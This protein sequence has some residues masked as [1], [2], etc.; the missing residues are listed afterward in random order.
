MASGRVNPLMFLVL[1]AVLS[2][3]K[4]V[5]RLSTQSSISCLAK[6][7]IN[8]RLDGFV[9]MSWTV[10]IQMSAALTYSPLLV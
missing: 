3:N 8:V 4:K 6:I 9:L 10:F 1:A 7:S 2:S 5:D